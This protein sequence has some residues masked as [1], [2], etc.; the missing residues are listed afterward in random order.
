MKTSSE[1]APLAR[2]VSLHDLSG[3]WAKYL[4]VPEGKIGVAID[5][6]GHART[7][8][9]A[10]RH[11]VLSAGERLRGKGV[12]LQVGWV[13]GE[14]FVARIQVPYLLSGDEKFVILNAV[15]RVRVADPV[16]F[17][18]QSVA[19]AGTLY[20]LTITLSTPEARAA[21]S[22]VTGQYLASDLAQGIP[23]GDL[24]A[25]LTQRLAVFL[26][27]AG[28]QVEG[29][30]LVLFWEAEKQ[31]RI[32]E[33]LLDL[34]ERLQQIEVENKMASAE[35]RAR[36]AEFQKEMEAELGVKVRLVEE[37][38]EQAVPSQPLWEAMWALARGEEVRHPLLKRLLEQREEN[39]KSRMPVPRVP[40][41]WW[42]P[43]AA[44]I[45]FSWLVGLLGTYLVLWWRGGQAWYDSWDILAPLWGFVLGITLEGLKA[46]Y[47]KRERLA[48]ASWVLRG[49][50]R[51]D[52]LV[53][54][55]RH[56]ADELVRKQSADMLHA[57]AQTL[58]QL[59]SAIFRQGNTD[60]ALRVKAL[61]QEAERL[62]EDVRRPDFGRP[63]YVE[64]NLRIG[65]IAWDAMLDYDEELLVQLHQML[66]KARR[67]QQHFHAQLPWEKSL[68]EVGREL[69]DFRLQFSRRSEA[70]RPRSAH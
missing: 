45:A 15:A 31:A 9:E 33:R 59:R 32:E 29:M 27:P 47:E 52:D 22:E 46:L 40:R 42:V 53:R 25:A 28:L 24:H 7:W 69:A 23:H 3:W 64:A 56:R 43:R 68:E 36:L 2:R 39:G 11:R 37:A 48:E 35:A 20:H 65:K 60:L 13:P 49:Y 62:A 14:P 17:F 51:V 18:R 10:G 50:T 8:A 38:E 55:D 66:E 26:A 16:R 44:I 12:G 54:Q 41:W 34:R 58:N 1:H 21:L 5:A 30:L 57:L 6:K 67:V 4:V 19:P 70:L 63:P 61:E